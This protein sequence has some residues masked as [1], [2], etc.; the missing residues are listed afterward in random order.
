MAEGCKGTWAQCVWLVNLR[1]DPNVLIDE[2]SEDIL[3]V[4][5][6]VGVGSP[7]KDS[8]VPSP[9]LWAKPRFELIFRG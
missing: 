6:V 8:M 4:L 9:N 5:V 1:L 3:D 2:R 7:S